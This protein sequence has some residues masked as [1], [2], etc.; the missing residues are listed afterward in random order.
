MMLRR[1]ARSNSVVT[2]EGGVKDSRQYAVASSSV[3][4]HISNHTSLHLSRY[5]RTL[6]FFFA[7]EFSISSAFN[8]GT[9]SPDGEKHDVRLTPL[10]LDIVIADAS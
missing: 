10:R 6:G 3:F 8:F 1:K 9:S 4:T 5:S 7:T 2:F